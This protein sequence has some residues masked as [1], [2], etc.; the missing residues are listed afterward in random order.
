MMKHP[1]L[2]ENADLGL[3]KPISLWRKATA[4]LLKIILVVQMLNPA[5]MQSSQAALK[6]GR[7]VQRVQQRATSTAR[8]STKTAGVTRIR[9]VARQFRG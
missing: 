2:I 9:I 8:M 4:V 1:F 7:C 6:L 5:V 3:E